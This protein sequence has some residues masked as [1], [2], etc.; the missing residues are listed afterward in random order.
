MIKIKELESNEGRVKGKEIGIIGSESTFV[1][2]ILMIIEL[3][4]SKVSEGNDKLKDELLHKI[5]DAVELMLNTERLKNIIEERL[6]ETN[7][8]EESNSK[9]N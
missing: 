9:S 2:D 7:G 4:V 6:K 1:F 3:F 8:E 5:R